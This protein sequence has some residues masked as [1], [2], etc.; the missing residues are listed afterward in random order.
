[1]Y[2]L[3]KWVYDRYHISSLNES[4]FA[5]PL[6]RRIFEQPK[7]FS[8]VLGSSDKE[9][10]DFKFFFVMNEQNDTE[11][12][13]DEDFNSSIRNAVKYLKSQGKLFTITFNVKSKFHN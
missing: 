5:V 13:S 1:M 9:N 2:F 6:Y 4:S 7:Y 12:V 10:E 11:T 8:F 3:I